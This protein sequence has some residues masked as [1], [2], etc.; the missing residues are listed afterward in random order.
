MTLEASLDPDRLEHLHDTLRA[1]FLAEEVPDPKELDADA[2]RQRAWAKRAEQERRDREELH[3]RNLPL[4]VAY[5]R[6]LAD[7]L[8]KRAQRHRETADKLE[9]G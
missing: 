8:I 3:R 9:G 1:Q 2:V 7:S 6:G 4:W 5:H